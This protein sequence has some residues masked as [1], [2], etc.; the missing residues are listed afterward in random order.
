MTIVSY[1]QGLTNPHQYSLM[2]KGEK[3]EL[4]MAVGMQMCITLRKMTNV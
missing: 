3:P 1:W 2:I 4:S